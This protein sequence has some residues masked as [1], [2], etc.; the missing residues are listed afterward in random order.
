MVAAP[1]S[2]NQLIVD[3]IGDRERIEVDTVVR[4]RYTI[5]W[6]VAIT[7]VLTAG[8]YKPAAEGSRKGLVSCAHN[9]LVGSRLD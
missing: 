8:V 4:W 5:A 2:S 3:R 1:L 9:R 7:T 6:N